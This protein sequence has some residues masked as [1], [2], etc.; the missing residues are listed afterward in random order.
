[1]KKS[2]DTQLIDAARR[3]P[4]ISFVNAKALIRNWLAFVAHEVAAGQ[5]VVVPGFGVFYPA[6][7]KAHAVR[8]INT[9]ER[10]E[11]PTKRRLGFRASTA[12]KWSDK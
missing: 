12:Q 2:L 4:G 9:G 7:S 3:A 11:L 6:S 1:M 5:K 8:D 10:I